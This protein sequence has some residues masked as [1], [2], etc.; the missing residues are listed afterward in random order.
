MTLGDLLA[1]CS[2]RP[3]KHNAHERVLELV[4]EDDFECD[5]NYIS[6]RILSRARGLPWAPEGQQTS[7]N[8]G[9]DVFAYLTS[10]PP[11][12]GSGKINAHGKGKE[13]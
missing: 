5:R 12:S 4:S 9:P 1:I 3:P 7:K 2:G 13:A 6:K 10:S 8:P 11:K